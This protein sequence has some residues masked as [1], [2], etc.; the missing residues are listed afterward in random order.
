MKERIKFLADLCMVDVENVPITGA[1]GWTSLETVRMV[2][3]EKFAELIIRECAR[4]AVNH[5][6]YCESI[7]TVIE[8]HFEK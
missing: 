4:V 5:E 6:G 7:D 8:E 1:D 3:T 2:D